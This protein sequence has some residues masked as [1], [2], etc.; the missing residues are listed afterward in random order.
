MKISLILKSIVAFFATCSL[1]VFASTTGNATGA[2]GMPPYNFANISEGAGSAAVTLSCVEASG[3][4]DCSGTNIGDT[5]DAYGEIAPDAGHFQL[6]ILNNNL[7]GFT[8]A[9][10]SQ[11][12]GS[13]R[14]SGTGGLDAA[15][16]VGVTGTDTSKDHQCIKYEIACNPLSHTNTL[17]EVTKTLFDIDND[18][19]N[20]A[21]ATLYGLLTESDQIVFAADDDAND[22]GDEQVDYRGTLTAGATTPT[23]CKIQFSENESAEEVPA[24]TYTDTITVTIA[25]LSS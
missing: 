10:K 14:M 6:D 16:C 4:I 11:E 25:N 3:E 15:G 7:L 18:R 24:A 12:G 17:G 2:D 9:L 20:D 1:S 5:N 22:R 21:S 13:L 23:E 8:V 19:S